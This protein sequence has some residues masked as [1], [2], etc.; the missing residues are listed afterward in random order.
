M[1]D[2]DG[3]EFSHF[4]LPQGIADD[5]YSVP[6]PHSSPIKNFGIKSPGRLQDTTSVPIVNP[7]H[8]FHP[9]D[10]PD[11]RL[12]FE[13]P[14]SHSLFSTSIFGDKSSIVEESRWISLLNVI[15]V[16]ICSFHYPP[17]VQLCCLWQVFCVSLNNF[18]R[19]ARE[20]TYG[21]IGQ[22]SLSNRFFYIFYLFYFL[23]KKIIRIYPYWNRIIWITILLYLYWKAC[24]LFLTFSP[25]YLYPKLALAIK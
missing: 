17:F 14:T 15:V 13:E 16:P 10:L 22:V 19:T 5:G 11:P 6:R 8:F 12:P 18:I 20:K 4:F 25:Q 2:S 9:S 1:A 3:E 7:N 23:K 24:S 21:T